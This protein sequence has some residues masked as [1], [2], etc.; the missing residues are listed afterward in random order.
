M[1]SPTP[2]TTRDAVDTDLSFQGE[3]VTLV[4]TAGIRRRGKI[5]PGIERY[6]VVRALRAIEAI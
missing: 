5:G 3:P 2:G 4:D 6:S 1:V